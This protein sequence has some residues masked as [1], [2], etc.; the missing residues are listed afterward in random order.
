MKVPPIGAEA[1]AE[2]VVGP[3]AAALVRVGAPIA[4]RVTVAAEEGDD[5]EPSV[6]MATATRL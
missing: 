2:A 4:G 1:V 5:C 6:K 3:V